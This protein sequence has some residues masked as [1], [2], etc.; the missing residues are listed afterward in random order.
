MSF[1]PQLAWFVIHVNAE[2]GQ[3]FHATNVCWMADVRIGIVS[4]NTADLLERCLAALPA[5]IGALEAEVVV[6]D[7]GSTDDSLSVTRRFAPAVK[8]RA[9]GSNLG[10]ARAMNLA[11]TGTTAPVLI[12]L[13]P[14]TEPR[15]GALA[16]LVHHLEVDAGAGL[17]VP[18]LLA[19]DGSL[20][21]SVHRFPSIAQALVM[22]LTPPRF[23]TGWIGRRWWLEGF[24]PHDKCGRIDWAVGAVHVIR[25]AALECAEHPYSE[26]WFMYAEDMDLCWRMQRR[27]WGV[28]LLPT[29]E[30]MHVGNAAG[31][32]EWGDRR[33]AR[34]LAATYDWYST[35]RGRGAA[36]RW[37][38]ANCGGLAVKMLAAMLGGH[39]EQA[40]SL[41]RLLVCHAGHLAD[42]GADGAGW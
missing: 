6:V 14:D 22:G 34:W 40:R 42:P 24:A 1:L 29:A 16:R 36:R 2:R 32:A 25:A 19:A 18:R 27:G 15:P 31:A 23:R 7:N 38:L 39:A 30:V 13:N 3:P 26:R 17:V 35:T 20:Q 21:P 10:Y 11:L 8:V 33:E 41:R 4:Y 28:S 37:C 9:N 12:A 5:A